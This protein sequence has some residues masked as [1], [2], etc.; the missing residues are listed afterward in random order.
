VRA[1]ADMADRMQRAGYSEKQAQRIHDEVKHYEKVREEVKLH[2]ADAIDL[3]SY[4][5]A[6]RHL[7]DMYIHAEESET[8]SAFGDRPLVELLVLQGAKVVEQ[9]PPGL[10]SKNG[11]AETIENNVRRAIVNGSPL[12]PKYYENMSAL[13]DALIAQRREEALEYQEYLAQIVELAKQVVNGAAASSYPASITR[14]GQRALYDNLGQDEALALAVD[15]A[16]RES[17][18]DGWRDNVMK[19]RKVQLAIRSALPPLDDRVEATLELVRKQRD[20]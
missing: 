5:P 15:S 7:I 11:A 3:K 20:Y 10:R 2:S 17:L 1:W 14:E 8:V 18:Q 4:E 13:L 12:N 6:M 19:T 16:V 9:L